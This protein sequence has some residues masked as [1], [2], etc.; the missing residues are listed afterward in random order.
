[1]IVLLLAAAAA[2]S[3]TFSPPA[4][5]E[6]L[7]SIYEELVNINTSFSTGQTTPAAEAVA[8]RLLGAGWPK[9]DVT[10]LGAASH[11]ANV[12]ARYRGTG[13]ARPL[14]L[15][16]HLDVVE[17]K[18]SDWSVD[19]FKLLEK[20]GYF[21]GRGTGD[22]KAQ[23]AIWVESLLRM[24]REAYRPSR[25]LV[26]ALTADEEGGGPF[27]GVDWLLKSRRELIDAELCLNEGGWGEM[28]DGRRLLNLVQV[29]EKHSATYRLEVRNPGG[30]SSMPVPENAI[31]RL[32]AALQRVAAHEFP[33]RLNEVTRGYLAKLAELQPEPV[34]TQLRRAAAGDAAAQRAVAAASPMWNA[35]MRTTCVA[36]GL[37][38]GH[39]ENA[40]PQTAGARVNCR[41][42]P[43][44]TPEQVRDALRAAVADHEVD[45]TITSAHG[46]SP[47]SPV[48]PDVIGATERLTTAFWPGVATLPYMVMGGTDG[49]MLRRAG[50][51]TYG[52]QGLFYETSDIRFHGRDERVGVH[53]LYEA[54]EFLYRLVKELSQ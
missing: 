37:D 6:L 32:A 20:E 46:A 43:D 5:R 34:A 12:V 30:H 8:R 40:L 22:D 49:R 4:D 26:L 50:I 35:V 27:N 14:L 10:V 44:E 51:P 31:Y 29:G 18:P 28:R 11:K 7:R 3:G 48:R 36:T 42:L 13:K 1:M 33:F 9:E 53:E 47:M 41:V 17:A 23:A 25:D 24:R 52:V 39:A 21:Y 15:L 54:Q 38:G 45:I 2:T 19:P 16:A